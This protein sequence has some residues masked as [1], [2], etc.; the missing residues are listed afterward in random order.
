MGTKVLRLQNQEAIHYDQ[1]MKNKAVVLTE[2]DGLKFIKKQIVP[3]EGG[4]YSN[5][6]GSLV[7][8]NV[9]VSQY[10]CLTTCRHLTG[11][12]WEGHICP[13]CNTEV[14][15]NY[16]VS[17]EKNGWISIG[18]N[19]VIIPAAYAKI[20]DLI[21]DAVLED[22]IS[23]NDNIDLQGNIVIGDSEFNKKHPFSKIG[24][25]EFYKKYEEIIS[26]YGKIKRKPEEAEF[27]L[28][29]KN[30]IWTS[31]IN[32]LSQ[33]L[34][35]A[36]INSSERTLRYDTMNNIYSVIIN[37]AAL[38][39]KAEMTNQYLNINKYLHTIQSSL[40]DLYGQII[41]KLDGKKKLL[42]RKM[43]GTKM[44][45]SSRLVITANTGETY[46]LDHIV[47]SYKAFLEL[48]KFEI[49]N[50]LLRGYIVPDYVNR[51]VY[52]IAEWIDVEK[53]SR[54]VHPVLYKAMKWLIDNNEDGLWCLVNRPP[55]MDLGSIQ[56]L[57]VVD[58][59]PNAIENHMKVPLTSLKAWNGD[60]DGDTLSVYSIKE[61][62]IAEA[63][64]KGFNPRNL[65]VD[66]VSG[67]KVYNADF[68]PPKDL[69]TFLFSFV[70][71]NSV[72]FQ[73]E[74]IQEPV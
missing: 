67:Y 37:N 24:M 30:R 40:F 13:L 64:G 51:T 47:I 55:T 71:E 46:G 50:C 57:R 7:D 28:K 3:Q 5:K 16:T 69:I 8:D 12:I 29:Y 1:V 39:A 6:L 42:R 18:T 9:N 33:E 22:I 27:L 19:K 15:D 21:G 23:F 43:Q 54:R 36:F 17:F 32:V 62:N 10:S 74:K 34:R 20:R 35:P 4:L 65:I 38:I 48:Y 61:K 68:G 26:Y 56:I 2:K 49:M 63:F 25:M 44:S 70:P 31:K 11:R 66:K 58:V 45:W 73:I 72:N 60:F 52:E 59:I 14:T 41:D 53:Y